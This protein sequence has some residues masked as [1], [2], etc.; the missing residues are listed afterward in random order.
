MEVPAGYQVEAMPEA[1]K[2]LAGDLLYEISCEKQ[3]SGLL[4]RRRLVM[5]ALWLPQ[6]EYSALR[7]FFSKVK[8]GDE[9]YM[10]LEVAEVGQRQ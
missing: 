10:V 8:A 7:Y 4:V 3:P 2:T 5:N 1:Q 9:Q 6:K